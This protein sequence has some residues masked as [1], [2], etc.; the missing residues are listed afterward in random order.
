M[1]WL[2]WKMRSVLWHWPGDSSFI[3]KVSVSVPLSLSRPL[4]LSHSWSSLMISKCRWVTCPQTGEAALVLFSL[5]SPA[6]LPS[7]AC[8]PPP[9]TLHMQSPG[10]LHQVP[11]QCLLEMLLPGLHL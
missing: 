7:H 6:H 3:V 5:V 4:A 8:G 10:I 1:R 9:S 11:L 2:L